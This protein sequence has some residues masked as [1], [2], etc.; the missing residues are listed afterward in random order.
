MRWW[1]AVIIGSAAALGLVGC[2]SNDSATTG[3][4]SSTATSAAGATQ[5]RYVTRANQVCATVASTAPAPLTAA[6]TR[7]ERAQWSVQR[8]AAVLRLQDALHRLPPPPKALQ[9]A[10]VHLG[11]MLG[12]LAAAY[13]A[14]TAGLS[15][16][17][18][19]RA[20]SL[21][22]RTE[23]VAAAQAGQAMLPACALPPSAGP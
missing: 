18:L 5:A 4:A 10:V 7:Q 2:G 22:R 6:A 20:Q 11:D 1:V 12:E 15:G 21:A 3:T 14:Q 17:S 9:P 13:S 23:S 16:R 8:K 19:R